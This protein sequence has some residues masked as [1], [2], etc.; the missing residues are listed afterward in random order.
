[1]RAAVSVSIRRLQGWELCIGE[2]GADHVRYERH[3]W[4]LTAL[5]S[6]LRIQKQGYV[7][8]GD[9]FFKVVSHVADWALAVVAVLAVLAFLWAV[10][11]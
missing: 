8:V 10:M 2:P 1:M 4:L 5:V 3:N 6:W 11:G 9:A 7:R